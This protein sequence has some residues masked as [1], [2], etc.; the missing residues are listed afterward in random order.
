MS[1][2]VSIGSNER[3]VGGVPVSPFDSLAACAQR[4][5]A[6]VCSGTGGFAIAINA[7]KVITC[8]R[9]RNVQE[10]VEHATLRY[11]DGAG[12]VVA[13]SDDRLQRVSTLEDTDYVSDRV[14][15]SA[16]DSFFDLL[17][18]Y[19]GGAGMGSSVGTSIPFFLADR[20]PV[21][22]GMENEY[23]RIL[24]D[25]GWIGLGAWLCFLIW[26]FR[27]IPPSRI[28]SRWGIGVAAMYSL[29][30]PTWALGFIGN[31]ALSAIP[32]SVMLLTMMGVLL[33]VRMSTAA[34]Q[35]QNLQP[36]KIA[37]PKPIPARSSL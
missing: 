29:C 32:Q 4:I 31:G 21:A 28:S 34:N 2:A 14:K 7:E 6:E 13:M 15:G 12:V 20:A 36:V 18:A 5:L 17:A 22:I 25:Q 27:S 24:I 37:I 10:T 35:F 23:C 3:N 19:P 9:D 8:S 11:P 26:T 33:K 16:N 30:L 1:G